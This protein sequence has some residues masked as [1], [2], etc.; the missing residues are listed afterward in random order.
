LDTAIARR[1]GINGIPHAL[2][3]D[4]DTGLIVA[5]GD[6]ARGHKLA[7]VIEAALAKK[8]SPPK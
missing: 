7:S 6:D 3:V 2:L 8:T 4:G 5:E 1:F